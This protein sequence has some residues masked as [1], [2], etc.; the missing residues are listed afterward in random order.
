[1]RLLYL[2][3]KFIIVQYFVVLFFKRQNCFI[4]ITFYIKVTVRYAIN[5]I[6]AKQSPKLISRPNY[7]TIWEPCHVA[8][9]SPLQPSANTKVFRNVKIAV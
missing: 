5:A 4:I 8:V 9:P 3:F 6:I 1:M 2:L 7:I